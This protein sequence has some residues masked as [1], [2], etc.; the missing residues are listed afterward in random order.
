MVAVRL[1]LEQPVHIIALSEAAFI[2]LVT[3][4]ISGTYIEQWCIC[5]GSAYTL[6]LP[7]LASNVVT[8]VCGIRMSGDCT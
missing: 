1:T 2:A 4:A 3:V 5:C 8:T 7:Q 6:A